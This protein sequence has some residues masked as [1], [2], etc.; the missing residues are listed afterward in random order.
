[1]IRHRFD[2]C[3]GLS[4]EERLRAGSHRLLVA[5]EKFD[6]NRNLKK[7]FFFFFFFFFFLVCS[8]KKF[9]A[10]RITI[11]FFSFVE[12]LVIFIFHLIYFLNFFIGY[13][14]S[15]KGLG[16]HVVLSY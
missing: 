6:L 12:F 4:E 5:R 14:D 13:I 1:M 2:G 16:D 8:S 10:I 9:L 3:R 11:F 7:V 15:M